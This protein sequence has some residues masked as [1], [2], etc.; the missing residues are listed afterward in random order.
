MGTKMAVR[1]QDI[2]DSKLQ[3]LGWKGKPTSRKRKM[4]LEA[5]SPLRCL[6]QQNTPRTTGCFLKAKGYRP[7]HDWRRWTQ[8]PSSP[9]AR[10]ARGRGMA[11]TATPSFTAGFCPRGLCSTRSWVPT[12]YLW[13][14]TWLWGR[15]S[16]GQS[17]LSVNWKSERPRDEPESLVCCVTLDKW[18][19]LSEPCRIKVAVCQTW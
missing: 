10:A 18:P 6:S 9:T 14:H 19:N 1:K 5:Q 12:L 2:R 13:R 15:Y 11:G 17:K 4:K 7:G 3:A 8:I 16:Q